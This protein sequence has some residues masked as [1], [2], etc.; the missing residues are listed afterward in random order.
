MGITTKELMSIVETLPIEI[1]I[2]LIEKLL[3]SLYPSQEEINKL[4]LQEA[5][6]RLKEIKNGKIKLIPAE[7]VF[8]KAFEKLDK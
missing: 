6:K 7:K 2:E 8:E 3:N 1:K 5:E 4:W